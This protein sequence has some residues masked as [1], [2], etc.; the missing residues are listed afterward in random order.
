MKKLLC[1]SGKRF[2]GKDTF[3]ELLDEEATNRGLVLGRYAFAGESKRLFVQAQNAA[4]VVVD[5]DRLL[6]ERPYKE[7]M[8]PQ[9][10]RFTVE[11][12]A[13]DPLVF[14]RAV[15]DRIEA[16]SSVPV[17]T[18][19]R[20]RLEVDHLRTRFQLHVVRLQRDDAH[21]A[22]AG[23]RFDP[24]ADTHHTE[25]ELDDPALWNEVID[26]N[27]TTEELAKKAAAVLDVVTR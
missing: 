14:C 23:W 2:S 3:A 5:L 17:V 27:G 19:L 7:A 22:A 8:R 9:L 4:G 26:N 15:A 12:I 10:T 18:D 25:T 11:S 20:L 24:V 1:I 6:H 16:S 21:R 13:K